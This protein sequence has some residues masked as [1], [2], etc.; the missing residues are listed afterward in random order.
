[1]Y[2]KSDNAPTAV[3]KLSEIMR[4]MIYD[5]NTSFVPLEKEIQYIESFIDLQKLR[6]ADKDCVV[7]TIS[8]NYSNKMIAPMLF[9]PFVENAFKHG[10]KKTKNPCIEIQISIEGDTVTF[11]CTNYYQQSETTH[12]DTT[13]GIGLT[14]VKRRLELIYANR[15][16]LETAQIEEKY[17]VRL[18]VSLNKEN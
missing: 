9:I 14:N 10:S 17:W 2:Q 6:L 11:W 8:G 3:M 15:Y 5:S 18:Q 1:V 13:G 4:Y 12:K 7:F 16:K